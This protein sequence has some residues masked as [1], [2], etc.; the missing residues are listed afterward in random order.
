MYIKILNLF[1]KLPEFVFSLTFPWGYIPCGELLAKEIWFPTK[2]VQK[3]KHRLHFLNYIFH[4]GTFS[5]I[6]TSIWHFNWY[7]DRRQIIVGIILHVSRC[8]I[9]EK[10]KQASENPFLGRVINV[11]FHHTSQRPE[12]ASIITPLNTFKNSYS[13]L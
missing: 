5:M 9:R 3:E 11:T 6:G 8:W 12:H 2:W 4:Q 7:S 10:F 1:F 13:Y